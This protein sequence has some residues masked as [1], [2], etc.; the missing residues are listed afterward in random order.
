MVSRQPLYVETTID[1]TLDELWE[2]SQDPAMHQRW[3]LRFS[4]IS[5]LPKE[6][7][8]KQRFVYASRVA[9]IRVD[10][11][12]ES[13]AERYRPDGASSSSLRFWSD[14]PLALIL[15]G[16]GFWRYEPTSSGVRFL[17][18]YDYKVR[19]G[20]L[21]RVVDSAL[22]RPWIG[23]ATAWSFD[24][25]RIWLERGVQPETSLSLSVAHLGA[26]VGLAAM[27]LYQGL[28]PKLVA[29]EGE[30]ALARAAGLPEPELTVSIIGIAQVGLGLILLL[31]QR[32]RWPYLVSALLMIPLTMAVLW[33]SPETFLA[34]FNPASLNVV[35]AALGVVGH[36]TWDNRPSATRCARAPTKGADVDL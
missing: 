4:E 31:M 23:W 32:W 35:V 3:D 11:V 13:L 29:P 19:W 17:T 5:Y 28:V 30:I 15:E 14:H 36:V 27:W 24:R 25:L 18:G 9:G 2:K 26:R 10:G 12:G 16:S 7:D 6:A 22:F 20:W 1:T 34:P 33:S 8:G 21:G